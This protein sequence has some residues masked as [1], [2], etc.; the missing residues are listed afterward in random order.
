VLSDFRLADVAFR[1][2]RHVYA[3]FGEVAVDGASE[4]PVRFTGRED[5]STG[6]YYHRARYYASTLHRFISEDPIDFSGGDINL[7]AYVGNR[8][9]VAADPLGLAHE[10]FIKQLSEMADR[11]IVSTIR[12]KQKTLY[13]HLLKLAEA[14]SSAGIRHTLRVQSTELQLALKEAAK[15]GLNVARILG[16]VGG[17]V[18]F[19]ILELA[20]PATAGEGSDIVPTASIPT[21]LS[22]PP[23]AVVPP[24]IPPSE[25][26]SPA[27]RK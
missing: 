20:D 25:P 19:I 6:L 27:G 18:G 11:S 5:D 26:E 9:T 14:E 4:N 24:E 1:V 7:Y 21:A 10:S 23:Q 22:A 15:R 3:P 2:A 16:R 8:P 17:V 12:S 13:E